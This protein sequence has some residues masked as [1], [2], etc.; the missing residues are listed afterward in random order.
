[1]SDSPYDNPSDPINYHDDNRVLRYLLHNVKG[2]SAVSGGLLGD[3]L[4]SQYESA[5]VDAQL[6]DKFDFEA[7]I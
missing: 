1:M 5:E 2:I 7:D 6:R 3:V 4:E